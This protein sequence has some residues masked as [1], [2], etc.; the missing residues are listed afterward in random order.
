MTTTELRIGNLMLTYNSKKNP[1]EHPKIILP[2]I[3]IDDFGNIRF[4]DN[5]TSIGGY[6]IKIDF[7]EGVPIT[8]ERLAEFGIDGVKFCNSFIVMAII[9]FTTTTATKEE[10]SG[11]WRVLLLGLVPYE[12]NRRFKYIHQIQNLYYELTGEELKLKS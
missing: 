6:S 3:G 4:R 5:S 11:R 10:F 9:P 8:K 1:F 7:V 2:I 12:V